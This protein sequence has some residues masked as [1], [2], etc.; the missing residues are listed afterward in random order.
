MCDRGALR[1]GV[2][3]RSLRTADRRRR[4]YLSDPV[5]AVHL[6]LPLLGGGEPGGPQDDGPSEA[7]AEQRLETWAREVRAWALQRGI[8]IA[9]DRPDDL[10]G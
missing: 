1:A 7:W 10:P 8:P 5:E 3:L 4:L 9:A 2:N 6:E